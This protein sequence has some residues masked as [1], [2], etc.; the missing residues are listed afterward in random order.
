MGRP[1]RRAQHVGRLRP[2]HLTSPRG[3]E[4]APRE[5][6]MG[7]G[8]GSREPTARREATRERIGKDALSTLARAS[9]LTGISERRLRA[10]AV[11]NVCGGAAVLARYQREAGGA[12]T[13][14][15]GRPRSRA[16]AGPTTGRRA[17]RFAEQV[18]RVIRAGQGPHHQRRRAGGAARQLRRPG[19]IEPAVPRLGLPAVG[20]WP[21]RTARPAW[22]ASGCPRRTSTTARRLATTATTTWP[23]GQQD[24]DIDYIVIHD[25]EATRNRTLELV[26]D[27]DVRLVALHAALG[28]RSHRPA[29]RQLR[30]RLARRQ[31]VREHALDRARA[32]GL[33][34][35][36]RRLVHRVALPEL[37]EAGAIPRGQ[38]RRP[39]RPRPHHRPRPGPG[40]PAGNV[41]GM[42]WDPGP[43]WDWEH[44]FDLLGRPSPPTA[45][46][47]EPVVTVA[48]G[49]DDNVQP[50][51]GCVG[52]GD[53]AVP[54]PG[55]ELRLPLQPARRSPRRS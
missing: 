33:R 53:L 30:R 24:M 39:A 44:Y 19:S 26:N 27:P 36:G 32:R 10:D 6:A 5:H 16:T 12:R 34:G 51:T 29:R 9:K 18:F 55:N 28:R 13:S 11:A 43:Y 23:T 22:V 25:T 4:Q 3:I 41:R 37:G 8:D 31:L 46:A 54:R 42:H 21:A 38:V 48:P 35:Q 20:G 40:H 1:R 49:F 15:T 45:P 14:A 17:L 2:M 50:V 47:N 7:K 52:T